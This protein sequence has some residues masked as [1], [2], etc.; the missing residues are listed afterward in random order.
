[1]KNFYV[2]TDRISETGSLYEQ[3]KHTLNPC[4]PQHG[5]QQHLT[6]AMQTVRKIQLDHHLTKYKWGSPNAVKDFNA[7]RIFD[8]FCVVS[9][10]K[11]L[12]KQ[13]SGRWFDTP[14]RSCVSV[15]EAL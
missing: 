14:C 2:D 9:L 7:M 13:P 8:V 12:T 6:P 3:S 15:M 5:T 1:M 4:K 10:Y 11:I